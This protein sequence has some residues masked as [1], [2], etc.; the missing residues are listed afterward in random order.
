MDRSGFSLYFTCTA[1]ILLSMNSTHSEPAPEEAKPHKISVAD[2]CD[3]ID[4]AA[5]LNGLPRAYLARLIWK[6][7]RFDPTA[8]SHA[9]A[10]GIAQFMPSTA[11][12][13]GLADP[14]NATQA[15]P[16]AAAFLAEL[17]IRFGN[18]GL[19]S[20]AY[21][22]GPGRV[23]GW[24][25]G[26]RYLPFETED[27]V[28]SI[29]GEPAEKFTEAGYIDSIKPLDEKLAFALACRELPQTIAPDIS[30]ANLKLKPWGIQVAGNFRR[31]VALNSW[32]RLR[33]KFPVLL[34]DYKPYVQSRR[35][36]FARRKIY[37]V[38]LGSDSR[39]EA[40]QICAKLRRAGGACVVTRN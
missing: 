31:H 21:N 19:A 37:A 5:K 7:S 33:R 39:K 17:K 36:A 6:E 34:S 22:A 38:R 2:I 32:N 29:L 16:A 23:S 14:Y 26:K 24:I 1:I 15:I 4:V 3:L 11:K 27:Y 13:R 28:L 9:G 8:Q 35:A 10:Q 12:L 25:K 30:M 20:A 18:L 40:D